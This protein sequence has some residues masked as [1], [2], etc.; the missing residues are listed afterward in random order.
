MGPGR[1]LFCPSAAR[2]SAGSPQRSRGR[3]WGRGGAGL[4]GA[5]ACPPILVPPLRGHVPWAGFSTS[6]R[7]SSVSVK[8][9]M[10][11]K[12][13]S[14]A[15]WEHEITMENIWPGARGTRQAWSV[16]A[17]TVAWIGWNGWN[18]LRVS[19]Q[20]PTASESCQ[21]KNCALFSHLSPQK[22]PSCL[23]RGERIR[24]PAL[25]MGSIS[26]FC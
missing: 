13:P 2:G 3:C 18:H 12:P 17:T 14:E 22:H 16:L 6:L 15:G 24:L 23:L 26:L 25:S 21:Q 19:G 4:R 20:H 5:A 9:G 1:S 7:V 8:T 11:K 10:E